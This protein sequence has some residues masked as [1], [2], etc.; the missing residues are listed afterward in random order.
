[1]SSK[2][3][4]LRNA[5]G[6]QSVFLSLVQVSKNRKFIYNYY[7]SGQNIKYNQYEDF[8]TKPA[9]LATP[10]RAQDLSRKKDL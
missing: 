6:S 9:T 1:V 2:R 3:V 7:S 5:K 4:L 10:E 8:K